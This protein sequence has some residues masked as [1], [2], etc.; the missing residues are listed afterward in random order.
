MEALLG[1]EDGLGSGD[2]AR[3]C[4]AVRERYRSDLL[5]V[6]L[7]VICSTKAHEELHRRGRKRG[8]GGYL[9]SLGRMMEGVKDEGRGPLILVTPSSYSEEEVSI[10]TGLKPF[11]NEEDDD[12]SSPSFFPFLPVILSSLCCLELC[13]EEFRG[14]TIQA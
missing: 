12:T 5:R 11:F 2:T 1:D 3:A 7:V 4:E 14:T 13:D 9:V 10:M 8:W 6:W